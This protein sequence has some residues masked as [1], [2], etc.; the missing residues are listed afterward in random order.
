MRTRRFLLIAVVLFS[1]V[2]ARHRAVV[3]P[4]REP[5]ADV[6]SASNPRSVESTHLSLDLTVDFDAQ[7]LRGSVTHTLLIH[8]GARQFIVDTNGVDVD[9]VF[10]DGA[11]AAW[12]YGAP[13]ANG[14]PMLIDVD[15]RAASVRIEYHTRPTAAGLHWLT[16]KQTRAGA[17]PAVWSENEP[18]FARS[19]IPL[20]DTPS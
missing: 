7:V 5:L 3:P 19:W 15:P 12:T 16:A 6:F 8:G 4:V 14:T 1:L 9:G 13:A 17:M 2:A 18:D 10:V 11:A 20:Q